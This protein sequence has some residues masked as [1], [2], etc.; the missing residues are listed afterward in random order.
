MSLKGSKI[1][2]QARRDGLVIQDLPNEV[3]VYDTERH[4][5]HCLNRTAAAVWQQ[6]DGRTS[7]GELTRRLSREGVGPGAEQAVWTALE[8]LEQAHLLVERIHAPEPGGRFSRR[9]A[10][11]MLGVAAVTVPLVTTISA[12]AA[13]ANGTCVAN[14]FACSNNAQCCSL[15][16]DSICVDPI[17][18]V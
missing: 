11:R 9:E 13:A 4:T 15:C 18:C 12:P 7:V 16:C 10:L 6:C 8:Q 17:N 14:G 5:A 2:P 1:V 3:L